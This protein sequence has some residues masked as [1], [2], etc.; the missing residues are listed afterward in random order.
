M[1]R[2]RIN[3]L[4]NQQLLFFSFLNPASFQYTVPGNCTLGLFPVP[5]KLLPCVS[6]PSFSETVACVSP[7]RPFWKFRFNPE[8]QASAWNPASYLL[9]GVLQKS[10]LEIQLL[11]LKDFASMLSP[12]ASQRPSLN[13]TLC[14]L[15]R[16]ALS[17]SWSPASVPL[18]LW[19]KI[20]F[21][22]W[23]QTDCYK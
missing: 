16:T 1:V 12:P 5:E 9:T 13:P 23:S 20:W 18:L 4:V 3:P 8:T 21:L 17:T 2:E 19:K 22:V 15:R 7:L 11:L 10:L 14:L 6:D